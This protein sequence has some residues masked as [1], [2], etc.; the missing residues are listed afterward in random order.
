MIGLERV[1]SRGVDTA[2]FGIDPISSKYRASIAD[3]DIKPIHLNVQPQL[4]K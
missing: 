2:H 1:S 3:T 4:K